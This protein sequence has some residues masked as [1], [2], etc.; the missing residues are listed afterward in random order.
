MNEVPSSHDTRAHL[1]WGAVAFIDSPSPFVLALAASLLGVTFVGCFIASFFIQLDVGVKA[2]G[3][4]DYMSGVK[5]AVALTSGQVYYLP[6]RE[7]DH[8]KKDQTVAWGRR[9]GTHEIQWREYI[10]ALGNDLA[11]LDQSQATRVASLL[12]T[13]SL[14]DASLKALLIDVRQKQTYFARNLSDAISKTKREL[15]PLRRR[16]Q[17][18]A[19]Q[20]RYIRKSNLVSYLLMQKQSLEEESGRIEQQITASENSLSNRTFESREETKKS[21]HLAIAA[22]QN[23]VA[24]HQIKSPVSG[25]VGRLAVTVGTVVRDQ[26]PVLTVLPEDSPLI[27]KVS[28]SSK[29]IAKVKESSVVYIS[30]DSYP[31]H[32]Y[33]YF[34]GKVL[35]IEKIVRPRDVASDAVD[36][37][38]VRISL[39]PNS[40]VRKPKID[41]DDKNPIHFVPG[42]NVDTRIVSRRAS[43]MSLGFDKLFGSEK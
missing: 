1:S 26:Q 28:V 7:G 37:Y 8:I 18:I 3:V 35:S 32:K 39:D 16:Q 15:A 43:L 34:S 11:A 27:A 41:F 20:L 42:M 33:G 38:T 12:S 31:S 22:L 29:D 21:L 36:T 4:T 5:D 25:T 24:L 13:T 6:V 40:L 23:Y 10:T 9:P 19:E 14:E 30:V 2:Q 17:I